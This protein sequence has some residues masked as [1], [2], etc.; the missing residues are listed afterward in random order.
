MNLT[1]DKRSQHP[2]NFVTEDFETDKD[3]CKRHSKIFQVVSMEPKL[4]IFF[5]TLGVNLKSQFRTIS[6]Y[7]NHPRKLVW[8]RV[9]SSLTNKLLTQSCSTNRKWRTYPT[10]IPSW[11]ILAYVGS[12]HFGNQSSK[13]WMKNKRLLKVTT[14]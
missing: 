11:S 6:H 14:Y 10:F 5:K 12:S 1:E 2:N 13:F 9:W 3:D 4:V 8:R 7:K